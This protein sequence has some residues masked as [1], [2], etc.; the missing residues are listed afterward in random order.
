MKDPLPWDVVP[1]APF[2]TEDR[3]QPV[4]QALREN[5][6]K[7]VETEK[8][9]TWIRSEIAFRDQSRA[10]KSVSLNEVERRAEKEQFKALKKVHEQEV[11]AAAGQLPPT[12]EITLKNAETPGLPA[13]LAL[14]ATKSQ[15]RGPANEDAAAVSDRDVIMNEAQQ[16][17]ADYVELS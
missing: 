14:P 17:L 2:N 3:V 7:R 12:Y 10:T 15:T 9:F 8:G 13:P 11:A 1:S 16:I 6:A 4:L 5:S